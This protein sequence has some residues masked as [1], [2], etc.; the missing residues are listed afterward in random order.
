MLRP[1]R[2]PS[3]VPE[4]R[5][6]LPLS[7]LLL[8]LVPEERVALIM[9]R[10]VDTEICGPTATVHAEKHVEDFLGR[11]I[12]VSEGVRL[13][14][15]P[16]CAVVV[17]ELVVG[18]PLVRVAEDLEGRADSLKT[19]NGGSL[20]HGDLGDQAQMRSRIMKP[21]TSILKMTQL[22]TLKAS[23]AWGAA[24]LSGWNFRASFRY[25]FFI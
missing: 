1:P 24:F 20:S 21:R 8:L 13:A 2:P 6:S 9:V 4:R 10:P 12:C 16:L 19:W 7:V 25:D 17:A 5:L 14:A 23:S 3:Y 22:L 11:D 18:P 15:H